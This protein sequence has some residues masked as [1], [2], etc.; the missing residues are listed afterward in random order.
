MLFLFF[1]GGNMKKALTLIAFLLAVCSVVEFAACKSGGKYPAKDIQFIVPADAGGGTDGISRKLTGLAE[2]SLGGSFYVINKSDASAA[3]GPNQVMNS[4]PDG[5]TIGAATY[6]SVIG[7]I[8][9]Q[10]IKGYDMDKLTFIALATEESDAIMVL[11]ESP[12]KSFDDLI[13]AAR[14][15]PGQIKIAINGIGARNHLAMLRIEE[16]YQVT[17]NMISYTTSAPQREALLNRE[18]EAVITSLGDFAAILNSGTCRGLIELSAERNKAYP[19]VPTARDFGLGDEFL[20]GSFVAIIAPAGIPPETALAL[21]NAFKDAITSGE[22][23]DWAS[24][25]GISARFLAG[26][27]CEAYIKQVQQKDFSILDELK[28][29]GLI[30]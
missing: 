28:N 4:A 12:Y 30:K 11:S 9:N 16:K 29:Q 21:E 8:W 5:Y 10:F 27:D 1:G 3:I 19:G 7:S 25:N 6:D 13:Q 23:V 22:F 18:V 26:G 20:T 14:D 2:K 15:K 24:S 17:F